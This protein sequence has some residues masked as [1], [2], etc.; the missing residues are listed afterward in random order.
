MP[1]T[2]DPLVVRFEVAMGRPTVTV[3]FAELHA[4][5]VKLS[6]PNATL[7]D[8]FLGK[9]TNLIHWPF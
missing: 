3:R 8:H 6:M 5:Q 9:L 7:R 1:V 2:I 4:N